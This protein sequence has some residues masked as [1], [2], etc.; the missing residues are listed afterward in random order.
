MRTTKEKR[1]SAVTQAN[2]ARGCPDSRGSKRRYPTAG[3]CCRRVSLSRPSYKKSSKTSSHKH[4]F[5]PAQISTAHAAVSESADFRQE[6]R[7][8]VRLVLFERSE[9]VDFHYRRRVVSFFYTLQTL[10]TF[11]TLH[12]LHTLHALH[13]LSRGRPVLA[14][15]VQLAVAIEHEH[16][17][18]ALEPAAG[19]GARA[20]LR[21]YGMAG[22]GTRRWKLARRGFCR[23]SLR[24][25]LSWEGCAG[26]AEGV[27]Q[28]VEGEELADGLALLSM[29]L[30][31][32][33]FGVGACGRTGGAEAV[34]AVHVVV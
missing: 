7:R 24:L 19:F 2:I 4:A 9:G 31:F 5:V 23:R 17:A 14:H 18:L 1:K 11:H 12:T 27:A 34:G 8:T 3:R 33:G 15:D 10:H 21:W 25:C 16:A 32:G 6:G 13:A 22:G 20:H 28:V 26:A 29:L 30:G